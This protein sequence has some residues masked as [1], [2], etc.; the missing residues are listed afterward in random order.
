MIF[1]YGC[2]KCG[3]VFEKDFPIGKAEAEVPCKCGEPAGRYY[4]NMSFVLKGGGWPGRSNRMNTEM[5]NRNKKAGE[6][7]RGT[8]EGTQPKLTDQ[9]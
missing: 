9:R 2:K 8:W 3:E 1:E 6:R 4:G 5:T 7:M